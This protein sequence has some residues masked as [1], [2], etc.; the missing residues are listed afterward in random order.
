MSWED[1][2]E[3]KILRPLGMT[4]SAASYERLRDSSDVIDGHARVEGKVRVIARSRSKVDHAAGG[5]YSSIAD[6]SKWVQLHLAGGKYGPDG[7]ALFS[8]GVLRERW[9]SQTI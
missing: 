8:P 4:H 1:F 3:N 2:I 6:L 5:I 9:A 7:R